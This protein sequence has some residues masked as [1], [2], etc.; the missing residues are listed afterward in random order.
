MSKD[1][2]DDISSMA[3]AQEQHTEIQNNEMLCYS[4]QKKKT[5]HS[6]H[7][8]RRKLGN[9]AL[10]ILLCFSA[11]QLCDAEFSANL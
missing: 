4:Y 2:A 1:L 11:T 9:E 8:G 3:G 10:K 6:V 7:S 5:V